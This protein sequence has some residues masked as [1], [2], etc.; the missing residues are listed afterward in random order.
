MNKPTVAHT[1]G[2][3][4]LGGLTGRGDDNDERIIELYDGGPV[5]GVAWVMGDDFS[6]AHAP[7]REA[8]ANVIAAAPD[9]LDACIQAIEHVFGGPSECNCS[10]SCDGTCTQGILF[11]AVAK[12]LGQTTDEL[13]KE[14]GWG[15]QD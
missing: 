4:Q 12:A 14:R 13:K 3:W 5:I 7:Q 9:L 11:T 1:P 8:N 2:P 10:G 15:R 6:D